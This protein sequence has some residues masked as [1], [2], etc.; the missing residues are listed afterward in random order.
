[1]VPTCY[2]HKN[3]QGSVTEY[4][5]LQIRCLRKYHAGD[6]PHHQPRLHL[7]RPRA[8]LPQPPLLL[9]R[10][11]YDPRIGRFI[12]EDPIGQ[13]GGINLY[14]YVASNPV[15]ES[16]TNAVTTFEYDAFGN[17]V[18]LTDG[19][20]RTTTFSY[21]S[22]DRLIT[23]QD[24]LAHTK[25]F[26][27][28][29][30]GSMKTRT[31]ENGHITSYNYDDLTND[32]NRLY[33][34]LWKITNPQGKWAEYDYNAYTGN[35]K[36]KK[37]AIN[38]W[39]NYDFDNLDRLSSYTTH[40]PSGEFGYGYEYD[41][42]DFGAE[43]DTNL[44]QKI[45]YPG[46]NPPN[47]N[48]EYNYD[49][50]Y[51]LSNE[52]YLSG[53]T[54]LY[55]KNFEY[56]D[57]D[58]R[59]QL[60]NGTVETYAI[61]SLNQVTA[62]TPATTF[63][64]G[65]N[66]NMTSKTVSQST[67]S[68]QYD[69]E[70]RLTKITYPDNDWT[71]FVYDALGRRL[72][73]IEKNSSGVETGRTHYVY[74]G[75]DMIA[76]LNGT[77]GMEAHFTHGSGIDDPLIIRYNGLDYYYHKNH[78]GSV[79]EIANSTGTVVKSYK[80]DAFGN[81]LEETGPTINRGF[82]YT[83]R[84]RHSR[85]GLYY[86]RARFYDPRIGRFIS[87]DPIGILGGMNLYSYT[88]NGPVNRNDPLGLWYIDIN[89]SGG[90]WGG[91]TGGV[92]INGSGLYPYIGG[93]IVTPGVGGSITASFSNPTHG[94]NVGLQGQYIVAGQVGYGFGDGSGPFVEAGAGWPPGAS[95]TGY[96][97]FGPFFRKQDSSESAIC[98]PN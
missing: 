75:L 2:Y 36:Q 53:S 6:R 92:M 12:S 84:E 60:S 4:E 52:Y 73:T 23:I 68:F 71:E 26:T 15:N 89:V 77:N 48:H 10:G 29:P 63:G 81:I 39:T 25:S 40:T 66:G 64:Y 72:K 91:L 22:L 94:W 46:T 54:P 79:T 59:T 65:N 3:H 58:N 11:F 88:E 31:D 45:T 55:T 98:H 85:S 56:D 83:A 14:A 16:K 87:Q 34:A 61:N 13:E 51:R 7:H 76:E 8:P 95:L 90:Y 21:D 19:E 30:D 32:Y 33:Q 93:G 97:V 27:Y 78:L 82:T 9:S 41:S 42:N 67:T 70:N 5:E 47:A 69:Y 50:L 1:M 37:V 43:H 38:A 44:I 74:D 28:Y 86:Y 24:M 35:L 62:I 80:Y 18:S 17:L 96:Y 49:N 57:A 20:N